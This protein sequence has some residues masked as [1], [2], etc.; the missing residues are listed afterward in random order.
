MKQ[1]TRL[2]LPVLLLTFLLSAA[3]LT[4]A[5]PDA[6][7][8][9]SATPNRTLLPILTRAETEM[10]F[11]VAIRFSV[12]LNVP[13]EDVI[14]L[15]LRI[16]QPDGSLNIT[17]LLDPRRDGIAL[18]PRTALITYLWDF[19]PEEAPAPF[20]PLRY[21]WQ[22][23]TAFEGI[24]ATSGEFLFQDTLRSAQQPA[25]RWQISEMPLQLYSHNAD[26]AL[27][28]LHQN[29]LRVYTFVSQQTNIAPSQKIVIYDPEATFCQRDLTDAEG[30]PYIES[31]TIGGTRRACDPNAA[32]AI[33]ERYGFSLIRRQT[34][35][36]N[37]LQDR[38]TEQIVRRAYAVLWES[39]PPIPAW[40]SEGLTRLYH[41]TPNS[42]ALSIVLERLRGNRPIFTLRELITPPEALSAAD[43]RVWQAQSYLLTL[44]LAD[45][46]GAE[47]P[48]ALA[49][50]LASASD[51]EQALRA[52]FGSGSA[53][54][55]TEWQAWLRS[56]RAARA[57]RWTPYL[58]TTPT[59]TA[60]RTA[61][62]TRTAAP[63]RSSP[64]P[65]P[66]ITAAFFPSIT[67]IVTATFTALPPGS[68]QRPTPVPPPASGNPCGGA[69]LISLIPIGVALAMR[70]SRRLRETL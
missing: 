14:T 16:Y 47:A 5:Q 17:P 30:A 70:L 20:T 59:P 31:R 12:T 2:I 37:E 3:N 64:T 33:Y 62:P 44:Y 54:L 57:V 52:R 66:T 60:T 56:E 40:F 23:Q 46:A 28:L 65:L 49:R 18:D 8:T 29:A 36:F 19:T 43:L 51:F 58:E 26:L 53:A 32:L 34:L 67:P 63:P 1:S 69:P 48:F 10:L 38:L 41:T 15:Y 11:P 13:L 27:N 25:T 21:E 42:G 4:A 24:S 61:T 50:D 22:V 35:A 45:R 9:P 55:Y 6:T 68:L 7:P 39:A